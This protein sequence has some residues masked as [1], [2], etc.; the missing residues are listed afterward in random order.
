MKK[1]IMVFLI[2][3]ASFAAISVAD[4]SAQSMGGV[5]APNLGGTWIGFYDDGSKSPYVW[6]ITQ[7]GSTL[8]IQNVGGQTARSK[9]RVEGKRIGLP[10]Q[11]WI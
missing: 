11:V 1:M 7:T 4:V 9:G 8:A 3:I 2:A 5:A 6:A 10:L